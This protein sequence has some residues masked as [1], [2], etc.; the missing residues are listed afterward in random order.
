LGAVLGPGLTAGVDDLLVDDPSSGGDGGVPVPADVV[1]LRLTRLRK[2]LLTR[3]EVLTDDLRL[4]VVDDV[5]VVVVV[6]LDDAGTLRGGAGVGGSGLRG[7]AV[8]GRPVGPHGALGVDDPVTATATDDHGARVALGRDPLGRAGGVAA[9]L[10]DGLVDSR[11]ERPHRALGVDPLVEPASPARD[12]R[13][14]LD[15]P[16]PAGHNVPR[17]DAAAGDDVLLVLEGRVAGLHVAKS[18]VGAANDAQASALDVSRTRGAGRGHVEPIGARR[19]IVD[20]VLH[21]A[22]RR[23]AIS[24]LVDHRGYIERDIFLTKFFKQIIIS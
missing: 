9:T 15:G 14:L 24:R 11:A 21:R 12:D 6:V 19:G 16:G 17:R 20:V 22:R 3:L 23:H 7:G 4:G 5:V 2:R 18:G 10:L 13:L 8:N 1:L